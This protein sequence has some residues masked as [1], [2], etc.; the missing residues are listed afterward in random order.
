MGKKWGSSLTI[1]DIAGLANVSTATVSR[2]LNDKPDVNDETRRRVLKLIESERFTPRLARTDRDTIGVF[3][4]FTDSPLR[5]EYVSEALNGIVDVARVA[6]LNVSIVP[7][8]W[9]Q[10]DSAMVRA[11]YRNGVFLGF[12]L[13]NPHPESG[14]IDVVAKD[15]IPHVVLGGRFQDERVNWVIVDNYGGTRNV[16][17]HLLALG[18]SRIGIVVSDS[19]N[20]DHQERLEMYKTVLQ[21]HGHQADSELIMHLDNELGATPLQMLRTR[22]PP[23]AILST[24]YEHTF[25]LICSLSE[26]GFRV[27]EDVSVAGFGDYRLARFFKPLI[28]TV[29]VP[30]Y[31]LGRAASTGLIKVTR[32]AAEVTYRQVLETE[33]FAREST[34][35]LECRSKQVSTG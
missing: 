6:G 22:N 3:A 31:D 14:M 24:S 30:A 19:N 29:R 17:E 23:T 8:D 34:H 4:N 1:K 35:K 9:V 32:T 15:E 25:G 28:T 10:T 7:V 16:M 33:F 27:P 18:H 5:I 11:K 21:E 26:A 2:V 13:M 12:I 20:R